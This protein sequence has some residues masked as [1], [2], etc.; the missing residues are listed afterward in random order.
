[1]ELF[2]RRSH[3]LVPFPSGVSDDLIHAQCL[4]IEKGCLEG[5]SRA[6]IS[7]TAVFVSL[8]AVLL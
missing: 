3:Q 2:S 6:I 5:P 4:A 7:P 8:K 1:M